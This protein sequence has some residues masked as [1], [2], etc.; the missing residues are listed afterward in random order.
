LFKLGITFGQL[1]SF[2]A[3]ARDEGDPWVALAGIAMRLDIP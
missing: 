3:S 1:P 2:F